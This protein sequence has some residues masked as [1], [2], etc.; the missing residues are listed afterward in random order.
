M[1]PEPQDDAHGRDEGQKKRTANS[2]VF[3]NSGMTDE[4]RRKLRRKQRKLHDEVA[5]EMDRR[6]DE[7][8]LEF[9]ER[10]RGDNNKL[11]E[12]VKFTREAVLDAENTELLAAKSLHQLDRLVQVRLI[13]VGLVSFTFIS[14]VAYPIVM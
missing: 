13:F 3:E 12:S 6:E 4:H 7:E 5:N 1:E 10:K 8:A 9:L 2:G 14:N 11:F